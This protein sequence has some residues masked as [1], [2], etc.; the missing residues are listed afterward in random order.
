LE[1]VA[2]AE[3]RDL[4]SDSGFAQGTVA[5]VTIEN[6]SGLIELLKGRKR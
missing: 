6:V 3:A 2:T 5:N 1:A 4:V